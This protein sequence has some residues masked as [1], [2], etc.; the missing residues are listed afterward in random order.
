MINV[1]CTIK[2][3]ALARNTNT[4]KEPGTEK[5]MSMEVYMS[6]KAGIYVTHTF[7]PECFKETHGRDIAE[8]GVYLDP[9]YLAIFLWH[10]L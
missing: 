10:G 7:C 8:N 6:E 5:W 9:S 1:Y 3:S 2:I 4:N